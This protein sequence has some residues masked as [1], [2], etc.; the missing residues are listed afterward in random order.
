MRFALIS[1][2]HLCSRTRPCN[3]HSEGREA[4]TWRESRSR[5]T[6]GQRVEAKVLSYRLMILR[7]S[8]HDLELKADIRKLVAWFLR[9][10]IGQRVPEGDACRI[11][12]TTQPQY[13]AASDRRLLQREGRIIREAGRSRYAFPRRSANSK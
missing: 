1:R 2:A 8:N 13:P 4:K 10:S 12:D 11:E 6:T 9:P 3:M 5:A 7:F